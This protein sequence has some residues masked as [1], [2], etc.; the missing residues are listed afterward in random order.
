VSVLG[1]RNRT[2][3]SSNPIYPFANS[4]SITF[5]SFFFNENSGALEYNKKLVLGS[6]EG[7]ENL[8]GLGLYA[9]N[10]FLKGSLTT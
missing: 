9:D 10:V 6:L 8:T 2:I 4:N 5:S 3:E 7:I 1:G